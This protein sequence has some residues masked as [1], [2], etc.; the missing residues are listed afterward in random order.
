M[1][2]PPPLPGDAPGERPRRYGGP[3]PRPPPG[4]SSVPNARVIDGLLPTDPI[5]AA[6]CWVG[7]FGLM[8]CAVGWLLGPVAIALGIMALRKQRFA[9]SRFGRNASIAR[10]W[11]GIS[12]GSL[13]L[14]I[15]SGLVAMSLAQRV[16]G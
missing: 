7:L 3:T 14:V 13:A 6:S 8:L 10:A 11:I 15:G 9:E 2:L 4:A 5:A 1:S 12:S 16:G